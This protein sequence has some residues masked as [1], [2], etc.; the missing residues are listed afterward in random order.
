MTTD[1]AVDRDVSLAAALDVQPRHLALVRA[2]LGRHVPDRTVVAFGSRVPGAGV[3]AK[4]WSDLDVAILGD[5]RLPRVVAARLVSDFE[6]SALPFRVDV[7]EWAAASA[8]FR[9]RIAD[10]SIVLQPS[11]GAVP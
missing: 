4:P 10:R 7:V 9:Q 6:E 1:A 11:A 8:A 2:I 5:Q 3:A